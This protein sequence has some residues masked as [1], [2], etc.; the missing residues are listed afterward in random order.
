[1]RAVLALDPGSRHQGVA[2]LVGSQG[3]I[4]ALAW[5]RQVTH[6][7]RSRGKRWE[8]ALEQVAD[9]IREAVRQYPEVELAVEE[10]PTVWRKAAGR[11]RNQSAAYAIGLATGLVLG[12]WLG[13]GRSHESARLVPC[14]AWRKV[15]RP[16]G[17]V[18]PDPKAAAQSWVRAKLD[19]EVATDEAEAICLGVAAVLVPTLGEQKK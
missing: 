17:M 6:A 8:R 12:A 19:R 5:S 4:P 9:A 13:A 15:M 14:G 1:M 18:G 10:P 7:N 2:L 11:E 16:L 3:R